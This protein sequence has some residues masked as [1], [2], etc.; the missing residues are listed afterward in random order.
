[1]RC[2]VSVVSVC[3]AAVAVGRGSTADLTLSAIRSRSRATFKAADE[4]TR[5]SSAVSGTR[6]ETYIW[7]LI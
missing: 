6:D 4:S 1:M 7:P 3:N 2:L 5:F